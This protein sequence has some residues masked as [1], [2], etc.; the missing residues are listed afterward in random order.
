MSCEVCP[1][2]GTC[3][4][5]FAQHTSSQN[6]LEHKIPNFEYRYGAVIEHKCGPGQGIRVHQRCSCGC[7]K[8]SRPIFY[9]KKLN[10]IYSLLLRN[11]SGDIRILQRL[12]NKMNVMSYTCGWDG[13]WT[14]VVPGAPLQCERK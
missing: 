14:P 4:S 5:D 11:A 8:R 1:D 13:Q 3:S 6:F 12:S 10:S 9:A 7:Q 2:P